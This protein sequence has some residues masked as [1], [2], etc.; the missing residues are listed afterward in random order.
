VSPRSGVNSTSVL[1]EWAK[2]REV[3]AYI[4]QQSVNFHRQGICPPHWWLE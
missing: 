1:Q 4:L 2:K 3:G